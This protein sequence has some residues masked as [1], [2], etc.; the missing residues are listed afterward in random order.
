MPT[1][2]T[3]TAQ[4]QILDAAETLFARQGFGPTTIKEIGAKAELNPALLYYYFGSKEELYKAVLQRIVTGLAARGTEVI[5][6]AAAPADA[7]RALVETQV[8]FLLGNP[9]M[10]KLLVR[11]MIDHEAKHAEA[12]VL[13]LAAGLFHRL[14]GVIERGQREGVFRTDVEPRYAAVSTISQ[15]VYFMIARPAIAIFFGLAPGGVPEDTARAFG[16]HAG[17]FAVRALSPVEQT[18]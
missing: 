17:D 14:C 11:E 16:R 6:S 5:E 1:D 12:V 2:P 18:A 13:K 9:N 10:P 4:D 3:P 7:I 15:V 8:E